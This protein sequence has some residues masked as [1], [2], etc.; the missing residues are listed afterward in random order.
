MVISP[1]ILAILQLEDCRILQSQGD[2]VK[3]H[4]PDCLL[5]GTECTSDRRANWVRSH[6]YHD[7]HDLHLTYSNWAAPS[8]L[9]PSIQEGAISVSQDPEVLLFFLPSPHVHQFRYSL[10]FHRC[11]QIWSLPCLSR[12]RILATP[13]RSRRSRILL[14]TW[15]GWCWYTASVCWDLWKD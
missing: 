14:E 11:N 9:R 7:L 10:Q 8:S 1:Y 15:R 5:V 13:A 4:R 2:R 12:V 6:D 3:N